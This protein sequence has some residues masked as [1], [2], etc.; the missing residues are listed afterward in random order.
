LV[1][2]PGRGVVVTVGGWVGGS[3]GEDGGE[4][5]VTAAVGGGR[6]RGEGSCVVES[7]VV[8]AVKV[9]T[10]RRPMRKLLVLGRE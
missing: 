9:I 5:S 2:V 10:D 6:V 1:G 4:T 7:G 8:Q 3:V